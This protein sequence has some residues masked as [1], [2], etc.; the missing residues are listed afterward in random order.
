VKN[1]NTIAVNLA[2]DTSSVGQNK[3]V[4]FIGVEAESS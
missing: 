3:T 2:V 1:T 4:K